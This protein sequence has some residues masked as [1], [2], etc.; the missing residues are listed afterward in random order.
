MVEK[1]KGDSA[2]NDGFEVPL[3]YLTWRYL[4]VSQKYVS[5]SSKGW[6]Q[7]PLKWIQ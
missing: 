4:S 3:R 2:C 6:T 5:K 1:E 7:N